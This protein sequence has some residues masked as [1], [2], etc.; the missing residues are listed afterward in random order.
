MCSLGNE[1]GGLEDLGGQHGGVMRDTE[2]RCL[3]HLLVELVVP[4]G[5]AEKLL[6]LLSSPLLC[7]VLLSSL[8]L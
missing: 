2:R 4:T 1:S 8:F 6:I 3:H 7:C 5:L